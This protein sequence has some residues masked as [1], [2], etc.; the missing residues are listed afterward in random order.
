MTRPRRPWMKITE[1]V[2]CESRKPV[3]CDDGYDTKGH[4]KNPR[5]IDCCEAHKDT[6]NW[7]VSPLER[8]AWVAEDK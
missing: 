2:V 6:T 4:H 5:C 7:V 3:C 8:L 1:C